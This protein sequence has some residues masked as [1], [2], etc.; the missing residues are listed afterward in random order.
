MDEL[1]QPN[2]IISEEIFGARVAL[3]R[4]LHRHP[5]LSAQEER[6]ARTIADRLARLEG[7]IRS[8]DA[9]VRACPKKSVK[10]IAEAVGQLYAAAVKVEI[11]NG[12]PAA[13]NTPEMAKLAREA[14]EA[15]VGPDRVK[16]LHTANMG[17]EDFAYYLER[18]RGC[19]IRFGGRIEGKEG[20][21]AHS[22]QID[23]DERALATDAAWFAQIVQ[24][25]GER[26]RRAAGGNGL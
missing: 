16:K 10:R 3:R 21:P 4:D 8:Q 9:K 22:S 24:L 11:E 5:E 25:A 13:H 7:T 23:F 20:F 6:T 18:V 19:Y 15:V 17:G 26:L 14:A 12:S 2:K 1:T